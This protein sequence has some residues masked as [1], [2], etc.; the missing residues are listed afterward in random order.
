MEN[1][2]STYVSE[3]QEDQEVQGEQKVQEV[4]AERGQ[5]ILKFVNASFSWQKGASNVL[6]SLDLS[7][8]SAAL[9]VII[10][11]ILHSEVS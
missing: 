10:G 3:E 11:K 5:N 2:C 9:T 4:E 6:H 1:S 7:I 8:P